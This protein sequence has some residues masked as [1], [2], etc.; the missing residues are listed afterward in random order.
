MLMV[1]LPPAESSKVMLI[2]PESAKDML[3]VL[4]TCSLQAESAKDMLT[5]G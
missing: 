1:M 3:R 4:G 2:V 5:P